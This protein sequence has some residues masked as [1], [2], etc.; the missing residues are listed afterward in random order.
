VS[1]GGL[2][3]V[4][5]MLQNRVLVNSPEGQLLASW[6]GLGRGKGRFETPVGVAIDS[7][8]Y[9]YVADWDN[10]LVQKFDAHGRFLTSWQARGQ[11]NPDRRGSGPAGA[12]VCDC[13]EQ[14]ICRG[15]RCEREATGPFL[16][17]CCLDAFA[18]YPPSQLISPPLSDELV[19]LIQF[20]VVQKWPS[21]RVN[22]RQP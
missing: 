22:L 18:D 11:G 1:G 10:H 14:R 8:G 7:S 9:V 3:H 15:I 12:R 16:S 5:D 17:G 6:G 20:I 2:V 13:L 21:G 4:T 19:T